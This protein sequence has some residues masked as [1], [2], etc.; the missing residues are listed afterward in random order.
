MTK[1]ELLAAGWECTDPDTGQWGRKVNDFTWEYFDNG[2]GP[3]DADY[4]DVR[5]YTVAQIESTIQAYGY[6]LAPGGP[7]NIQSIYG[8]S[9]LQIIAECL[10]EMQE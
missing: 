6:T 2:E 3:E 9:Y 7:D 1:E 5:R 10:F 4:I 8:N